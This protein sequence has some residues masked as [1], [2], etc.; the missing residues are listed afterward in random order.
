MTVYAAEIIDGIVQRVIVAPDLDW[1]AEHL[2]GTWIETS[3]PYTDQPQEVA[4]CGIGW[5]W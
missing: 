2:G 1:C 5:G 3:D 4:Y